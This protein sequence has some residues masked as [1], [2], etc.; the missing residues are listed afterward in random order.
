[1]FMC[2]APYYFHYFAALLE[3]IWFHFRSQSLMC[4]HARNKKKKN[5][6]MYSR[7]HS[8]IDQYNLYFKDTLHK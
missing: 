8:L 6:R 4:M 1:M 2:Y 7:I 3:D 5:I